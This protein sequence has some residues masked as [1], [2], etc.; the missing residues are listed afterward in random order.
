MFVCRSSSRITK[1]WEAD[2]EHVV[3]LCASE[4]SIWLGL[5]FLSPQVSSKQNGSTF[6]EEVGGQ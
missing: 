6:P 3:S 4:K 2:G 5:N 1:R